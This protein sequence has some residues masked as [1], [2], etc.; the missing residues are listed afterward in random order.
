MRID[1]FTIAALAD[2]LRLAVMGGRVQQIWQLTPLSF[3]LEIY[4]QR[5]RRYLHLSADPQAP[6][7]YLQSTKPRRGAGKPTPL[8]QLFRKY[9]RG[10]LLLTVEQPPFE[11]LLMFHFSGRAG[12]STTVLEMLGSRS[13]LLFLDA[14]GRILALARPGGPKTGPRRALLPNHPYRLPRPQQKLTP[15]DLTPAAL[16]TALSRL[17]PETPLGK[18]LAGLLH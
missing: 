14:A 3:E 5:R 12:E 11:R 15:A 17:P 9:L 10:S 7:A 16:Q 18:A 8:T 13:N 1:S 2:E 4:A 6:C